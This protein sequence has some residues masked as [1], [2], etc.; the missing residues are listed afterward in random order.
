MGALA[1]IAAEVQT[2][3]LLPARARADF[4]YW[5]AIIEP[6]LANPPGN[7]R[8]ALREVAARLGVPAK[9]VQNRYYAALRGGLLAMVDKRK[10][11][12]SL[13]RRRRGRVVVTES[14]GLI[15]LWRRLCEEGTRSHKTAYKR[16]V[17]MF[18][19][20]A[21][22]IRAI[23]EFRDW[24]GGP[25]RPPGLSYGNMLRHAPSEFEQALATRGRTAAKAHRPTMRSGRT[26]LYVG[27]HYMIDDMWHNVFVN[28]FADRQAGRA[29]ELYSLDFFSGCKMRWGM[30]VRVKTRDGKYVGM[31]E[32]D[33]ICTVAATLYLDGFAAS[34]DRGTEIV[35]EHATAHLP[36]RVVRALFDVSGGKITCTASGLQ[37]EAAHAG[38]YPTFKL[39][40]P[41]F[42]APVE[43]NHNLYQNRLDF[44]PGQTGKDRDDLPAE[45]KGRLGHNARLLDLRER[46]PAH[47]RDGVIFPILS[48]RDFVSVC[49]QAQQEIEDERDH[50]LTGWLEAGNVIQMVDFGAGQAVPDYLLNDE[51]RAKLPALLE[52]GMVRVY[53]ARMTRGEVKRRGMRGLT[54]MDGAAMCMVLGDDFAHDAPCGNRG[55]TVRDPEA[56]DEPLVFSPVI[57]DAHGRE[58]VL[59]PGEKYEGVLNPIVPD[60]VFVRDAAGRYLGESKI[61]PV[62]TRG[63]KEATERA[64]GTY[65]HVE[66]VMARAVRERHGAPEG[67]RPGGVAGATAGRRIGA[68]ATAGGG[69]GGGSGEG[70]IYAG[71]YAGG[72]EESDEG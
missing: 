55:L 44:L 50:Q 63:D 37:H 53:Q 56:A 43:S 65:A 6:L 20:A 57:R 59:R 9:T 16:L 52:M 4:E 29:L 51:Q 8:K 7:L 48:L 42:K 45:L 54:R 14:E 32:R 17:Q 21:P 11:G 3:A 58:V 46:M 69:S 60:M 1:T 15:S 72:E 31:R 23:P 19:E 66:N 12:A 26:G 2:L 41:G 71:D 24:P 22:E 61:L 30:R 40:N 27:S 68:A 39:G 62:P 67:W 18:R 35:M 33:A 38:Q 5:R 36:D 64:W 49:G 28:S 47:M 34:A 10:C 13:W 70:N 25:A